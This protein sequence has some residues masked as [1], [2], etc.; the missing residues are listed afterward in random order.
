MDGNMINTTGENKAK[1]VVT[2]TLFTILLLLLSVSYGMTW[3]ILFIIYTSKASYDE[4]CNNLMSWDKALYILQ[5]ISAGLHIVSSV[6]Q[7][8]MI[9]Y[10]KEST[11]PN[12]IMGCRSCLVYV[13][14]LSILLGI[15]ISYFSHPNIDICKELKT[16]NFAYIITEWVILG[17]CIGLVCVVCIIS[18][19]FKRRKKRGH[20]YKTIAK[21]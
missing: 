11:I 9:S 16:I 20:K 14:G 3:G 5:F 19:I 7:L 17:S 10:D 15:N 21:V 13:A 1:T 12:Y 2:G 4:S 8:V 6:I 18:I